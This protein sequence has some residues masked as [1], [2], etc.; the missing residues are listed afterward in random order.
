MTANRIG[1]VP[2]SHKSTRSSYEHGLATIPIIIRVL[3]F[4]IEVIVLS[5]VYW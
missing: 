3:L 2:L 4:R 1:L 5:W